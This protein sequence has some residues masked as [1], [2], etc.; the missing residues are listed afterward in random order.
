MSGTGN[1]ADGNTGP[2]GGAAGGDAL[3]SAGSSLP[4]T[5]GW[6]AERAKAEIDAW[7][8]QIARNRN[9][10]LLNQEHPQH[11]T[12][13]AHWTRLHEIA[14]ASAQEPVNAARASAQREQA[15]PARHA[16]A[17]A[18]AE[19]EAMRAEIA[20][21]RNHA[22]F[23]RTHPGHKAVMDRWTALHEA[24]HGPDG[25]EAA[26]A[27][28]EPALND[29]ERAALVSSHL[30]L[31]RVTV[32]GRELT[33]E[34]EAAGRRL[35]AET[36]AALNLPRADAGQLVNLLNASVKV[37]MSIEQGRAELAKALGSEGAEATLAEAR[38]VVAHL[39][40]AGVPVAKALDMTGAGNNPALIR[41]LAGLAPRL[42]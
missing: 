28:G 27:A 3:P 23:D 30:N 24:A 16:A 35:A 12:T 36:I 39:E 42:R 1:P 2:V 13:L 8:G 17:Q 19:I 11:R 40:R 26:G 14:H 41:Y 38:R 20:A 15:I 25:T 31:S 32:E 29:T 37:P 7:G 33:S 34:D 9:H 22:F 4:D 10:A 6:T 18:T 21:D 5:S